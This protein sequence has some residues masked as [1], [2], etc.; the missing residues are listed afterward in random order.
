MLATHQRLEGHDAV[1][2]PLGGR[3]YRTIQIQAMRGGA[4]ITDVGVI[5]ADG[6]QRAYSVNGPLDARSN[7]NLR[8]HLGRH[9]LIGVNAVVLEGD[10]QLSFRMMGS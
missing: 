5:F 10:G 1:R 3:P 9:G 6:S 8:I 7:P 4:H 2:M